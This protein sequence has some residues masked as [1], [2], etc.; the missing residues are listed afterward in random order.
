MK[1]AIFTTGTCFCLILAATLSGVRPAMA[2]GAQETIDLDGFVPSP[3]PGEFITPVVVTRW[4]ARCMPLEVKVNDTLDPIPNPLGVDFLRLADARATLAQ[5]AELW[6]AVPTSFV[7]A[8]IV[9][10]TSNLGAAR[11]DMINEVTFRTGPGFP[12]SSPQVILAIDHGGIATIRNTRLLRDFLFPDGLDIDGDGD[13]D[14]TA[15]IATCRDWDGDGDFELPAGTYEAGTILDSDIVFNTGESSVTDPPPGFRFTV[16]TSQVDAHPRSVDLLGIAVQAFGLSHGAAHVLTSQKGPRNGDGATLFAFVDT[17]DPRAELVLR[18]L[19]TDAVTG[20]SAL[21]PEGSAATGPAALQR[22]DVALEEA[23]GFIEGEARYGDRD[24]LL[25]GGSVF[26]VDQSTGEVVSA[27]VTARS[28][29]STTADGF[30]STFLDATF[31]AIDGKYRLVVPPGVYSVGIEATD[32]QPGRHFNVNLQTFLGE[33]LAQ[34]DFEEEFYNGSRES[35]LERRPGERS[36]VRVRRGETMRGIDITTNR[37]VRI[38]SYGSL[39]RREPTRPGAYYAV[40]IPKE[41]FLEAAAA[42]GGDPVIQGGA[43]LTAVKDATDVPVFAEALLTT[44]T[45][46]RNGT[47]ILDLDRPLARER[48]FV[49]QDF[50]FAPFWI[51]DP[52]GVARRVLRGFERG[53]IDSLF[54]VLRAPREGVLPQLGLDGGVADNDVPIHGLSFSS[55]DGRLF[56]PSS[57]FNFMFK[58]LL[59]EDPGR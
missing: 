16:R 1:R 23:F 21:Y 50:D 42:A 19:D 4:D 10:T 52:A 58:L 59:G 54:L 5:A 25:I 26:A 6:N 47:A 36:L 29:F 15:A 33:F 32:A 22:G 11:F 12:P 34:N 37:V 17:T 43:F 2:G 18:S 28:R 48:G 14:V 27:A 44:G 7:A 8:R 24:E 56:V 46:R 53:E 40:R 57:R 41:Q 31:H 13:L 9:G 45:V 38:A 30:N 55:P 3:V 35:D 39:D 51:D 49:G 20:I